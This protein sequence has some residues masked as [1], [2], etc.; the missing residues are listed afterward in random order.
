[1]V[2]ALNVGGGGGGGTYLCRTCYFKIASSAM[3]KIDK[4]FKNLKVSFHS[5]FG[6]LSH[7]FY[8]WPHGLVYDSAQ[9][10]VAALSSFSVPLPIAKN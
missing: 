6:I 4:K 1:M 2:H 3:A 9:L 10:L 7:I 5:G 8:L